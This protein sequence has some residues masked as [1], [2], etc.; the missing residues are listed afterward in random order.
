MLPFRRAIDFV[1]LLSETRGHIVGLVPT[2]CGIRYETG[3]EL[4]RWHSRQLYDLVRCGWQ[5]SPYRHR[6]REALC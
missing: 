6:K 3:A 1:A 5:H 2:L 4:P